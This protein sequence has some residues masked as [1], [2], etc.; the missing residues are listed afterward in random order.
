MDYFS[1]FEMFLSG[2][3]SKFFVR[4]SKFRETRWQLIADHNERPNLTHNV[5]R[6]S[7]FELVGISLDRNYREVNKSIIFFACVTIKI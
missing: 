6:R 2:K 5:I 4:R 7:L 1:R 3:L